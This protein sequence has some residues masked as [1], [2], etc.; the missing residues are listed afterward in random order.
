MGDQRK[1]RE[2]NIYVGM[3]V[4]LHKGENFHEVMTAFQMKRAEAAGRLL[5]EYNLSGPE[6]REL[7]KMF[8]DKQ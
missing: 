2:E 8:Q 4:T 5:D 7:K 6:L 3:T 1:E